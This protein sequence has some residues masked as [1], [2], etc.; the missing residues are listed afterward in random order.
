MGFAGPRAGRGVQ[1]TAEEN[2]LQK[3]GAGGDR[4]ESVTQR[5]QPEG[6]RPLAGTLVGVRQGF[7]GLWAPGQGFPGDKECVSNIPIFL[8]LFL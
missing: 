3:P 2:V 1:E 7:L 5:M 6:P 8:L 4:A